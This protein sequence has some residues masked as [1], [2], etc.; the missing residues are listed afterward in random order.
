MALSV[1]G[2]A[3]RIGVHGATGRVGRLVV[4]A[5]HDAPALTLAWA[6]GRDLPEDLRAD[7]I[8]DFSVPEALV[9]LL[10][11]TS[12]PVVSGTTGLAAGTLNKPPV[13]LRNRPHI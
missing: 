6:C 3:L 5:V 10:A 8:V 2:A 7:V 1:E 12:A 11:Y 9:R 4:E 13:A